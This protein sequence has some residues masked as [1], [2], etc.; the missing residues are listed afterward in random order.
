MDLIV[1]TGIPSPVP[2]IDFRLSS[3]HCDTLTAKSSRLR[4]T[5]VLYILPG[6]VQTRCMFCKYSLHTV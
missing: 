1:K 2:G 4:Q 5:A 6:A 3:Q